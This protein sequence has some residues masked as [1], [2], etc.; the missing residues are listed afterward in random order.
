VWCEQLVRHRRL[1]LVVVGDRD[2]FHLGVRLRLGSRASAG[3]KGSRSGIVGGGRNC[4]CIRSTAKRAVR[5]GV[6]I[7]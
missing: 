6:A 5:L 4:R 1:G 7:E 2:R 3:T